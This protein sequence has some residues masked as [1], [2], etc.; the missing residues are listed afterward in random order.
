ML[1][2]LDDMSRLKPQDVSNTAWAFAKAGQ[3]DESLFAGLATA[4]EQL[5]GD[6]T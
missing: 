4:A 1:L 6:F 2:L 3:N 5:I